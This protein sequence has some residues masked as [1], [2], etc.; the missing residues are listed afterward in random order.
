LGDHDRALAAHQQALALARE[1]ED[2]RTEASA[3]NNIAV[4]YFEQHRPAAA[5]PVLQ[6]ALALERTLGR[7]ANE[8]L[9][10]A[11]IGA[12][13][14]DLGEYEAGRDVLEQ[15]LTL[16]R[17]IGD[18][19][20]EG[21]VLANLAFGYERQGQLEAALA[22]VR[23]SIAVGE[24]VRA[25]AR[26]EEL[27]TSVAGA[28][29]R[30][31][32][33]AVLLLLRLGR[34]QEAFDMAER[35]RARS[36]LDQLDNVRLDPRHR[37]APELVQQEQ[38]LRAE[39]SALDRQWREA[40]AAQPPAEGLTALEQQL[41]AK[42]AAYSALL[43]ELRLA[44]PE[45]AALVSVEPVSLADLQR[46]LDPDTTLLTYVV[47]PRGA[48]GGVFDQERT[49]AFIVTR[50]RFEVVELAVGDA[51]LRAAVAEL[52]AWAPGVIDRQ[53]AY[54]AVL[55][56]LYQ[57]LVAP[58]TDRLTTPVV[59]IIP[60]GI[61]SYVPF[62]V[63]SDGQRYVGE[64][65]ILFQAASASTLAVLRAKRRGDRRAPPLVMAQAQAE[66]LPPL[67]FAQDEAERIGALYGVPPLVGRA[68]TET[69]LK[70]RAT[71]AGIIHLAAHGMLNPTQPLFSRIFLEPDAANDGALTVQ[72][73]YE[74]DLAQT[75]LVVL[76]ACATQLGAQS[77]GDDVVGLSRAFLYAGAP[78]VVA[79]LW[80]VNDLAT[81]TL[82]QAFHAH[83]SQGMGKAAALQAAQAETRTLF[84]HPFYWAAFVLT[85]DP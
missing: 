51:A 21:E 61:L 12:A 16:T 27:K 60:S 49:I 5:L 59:G 79:S 80:N 76:S 82:M 74:L 34:P 72:E 30:R 52:Y 25:A 20:V 73:V 56:R 48:Q 57:G 36:L 22:A 42:Q 1:V 63:L 46:E 69:A 2:R 41:T 50:D 10:L 65:H 54:P 43:T 6:E 66:S 39:I 15:A 64:S 85:G 78:T 37:A 38:T 32:E 11:N 58:V 4:V 62:A 71:Q 75:D 55:Q 35:A 26:L 67:R 40:L 17:T 13:D 31:Y 47:I 53:D 3:L 14:N 44:D 28:A 84:P 77:R 9:V 19:R 29:A 7:R 8:A 83:L 18:R 70:E 23:Q 68:A 45:S 33:L 24:E 81:A